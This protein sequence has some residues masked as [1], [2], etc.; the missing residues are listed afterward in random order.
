MAQPQCSAALWRGGVLATHRSVSRSRPR[1]LIRL[2]SRAS[3]C[4][5]LR[6]LRY[7]HPRLRSTRPRGSGRGGLNSRTCRIPRATD[8]SHSGDSA[9]AASGSACVCHGPHRRACLHQSR[10]EGVGRTPR[11][12]VAGRRTLMACCRSR[13]AATLSG[14]APG[15]GRTPEGSSPVPRALVHAW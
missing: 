6:T 9:W 4:V 14:L 1:H 13:G 8:H 15:E 11:P 12:C 3:P 2:Q 10:G 5:R 7:L